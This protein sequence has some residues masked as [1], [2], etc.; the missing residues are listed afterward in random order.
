MRTHRSVRAS[1]SFLLFTSS[2]SGV[3]SL[4]YIV[5]VNSNYYVICKKKK[6]QQ[7]HG[8]PRHGFHIPDTMYYPQRFQNRILRALW[9]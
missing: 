5:F 1:T 2:P 6:K 4:D 9:N 8:F 3:I 7:Q